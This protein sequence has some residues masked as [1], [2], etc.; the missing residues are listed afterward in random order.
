VTLA[1]E[2]VRRSQHVKLGIGAILR[3]T[4]E[5]SFK[6]VIRIIIPL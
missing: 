6:R 1:C 5:Q 3:Y 2:G 4:R